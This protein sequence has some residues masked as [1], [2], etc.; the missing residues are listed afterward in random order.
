MENIF[1][2][3][4]DSVEFRKEYYTCKICGHFCS[5]SGN[6][7]KHL[8]RNHDIHS[9][10]KYNTLYY[11]HLIPTCIE[12]GKL[13]D[14]K[15]SGFVFKYYTLCKEYTWLKRKLI[16]KL[17]VVN[18]IP[19]KYKSK[20]LDFNYLIH[21]KYIASYINIFWDFLLYSDTTPKYYIRL[22]E[23]EYDDT[24]TESGKQQFI[25]SILNMNPPYKYPL[26]C[27]EAWVIRGWDN[28][29]ANA[30]KYR[31]VLAIIH[32]DY[33]SEAQ[34]QR[35]MK[36][37]QIYSTEEIRNRSLRCIEYW[38]NKGYT[39]EESQKIISTRSITN[40]LEYYIHKFGKEEGTNLFTSRIDNWKHKILNHP[41]RKYITQ[42][43]GRS[44][45][46]CIDT[47][48]QLEG[49]VQY[50]KYH[51]GMTITTI[52]EFETYKKDLLRG[53]TS[54]FYNKDYRLEILNQQNFKCGNLT[55]NCSNKDSMFQLHHINFNKSDDN[56]KN[57][58]FLC[59]SCHASSTHT[60]NR[61][62]IIEYYTNLN[63]QFY[64]NT[65]TDTN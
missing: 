58:I 5:D 62:Q 30:Y 11:R 20:Y 16:C 51:W 60:N 63:K 56:R 54:K 17:T 18:N 64:D 39:K 28:V 23:N 29:N 34:R 24:W 49:R 45:P 21:C 19:E 57:L 10:H 55:C 2:V 26:H 48:G 50:A 31:S 13:S 46:Y 25:L 33:S 36:Q 8:K 3:T 53:Y 37:Y 4:H 61:K 32:A 44:L 52:E 38:L 27:N 7:S 65:N 35:C 42:K 43:Q 47:Y 22:C 1:I 9:L 14:N 12:S 6:L 59:N 15:I 41:D 40:G